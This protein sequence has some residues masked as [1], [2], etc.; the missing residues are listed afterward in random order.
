MQI[1]NKWIS[2]KIY[3]NFSII[4]S[5]NKKEIKGAA[6]GKFI[7]DVKSLVESKE[8]AKILNVDEDEFFK[9]ASK[10]NDYISDTPKVSEENIQPD[11]FEAT[12]SDE[13]VTESEFKRLVKLFL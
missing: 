5:E 4:H 10:S 11:L 2:E 12:V 1:L 13:E 8:I 3:N 9:L 7:S 6:I